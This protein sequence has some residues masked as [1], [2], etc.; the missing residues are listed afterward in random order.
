MKLTQNSVARFKMPAGKTEH[1]EFD[2]DMHG[3]GL[4]VRAGGKA[5][6]RTFI[7]QYK[8]GEKHR[9]ITLGNASKVTLENARREAKKI[10]GKVALGADPANDKAEARQAASHTLDAAIKRYL[11]ARIG[12]MKPAS[13][14]QAKIHLEK[15]WSPLH[16]LALGSI[17]RANVAP[18]VTTIAKERGPIAANRARATLSALFV[19]AIGEGLCDNNPVVGT[20]KQEENSRSR[21]L[22]EAEAA[23]VWLA[24]PEKDYGRIVRLLLLTGCRR[25]EIGSLRWSEI[26]LEART[27][28]L[29]GERTKN[30]RPHVVP[31]SDSAIAIIAAIPRRD[32]EHVFGQGRGGFS[33][34]SKAKAALDESA[35]LKEAWTLHDLRRTAA[36]IMADRLGVQPHIIEALLNHVSGHKA[37]VAGIYNLAAYEKEKAEALKLWASHLA[38]AVAKAT[39]ANVTSFRKA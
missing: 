19:W 5:E 14:E 21:V 38:A 16:S 10:F 9:R 27:I 33:G 25:D 6:H 26:D 28:T 31:L 3:F 39:G 34:W 18:V 32:R 8:I 13:Y 37:G 30:G 17:A 7:A 29:P 4:R 35:K 15:H 2:D 22:S 1:I 12:D 23:A 20:N 24:A 36:T 11:E